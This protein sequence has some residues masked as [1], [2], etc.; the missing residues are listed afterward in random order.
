[1]K[2]I[3][4][5]NTSNFSSVVSNNR[6]FFVPKFQRDYSWES[7][8][9]DDLWQDIETML[10]EDEEHYMGYLVLQTQDEK[11][12]HI[13]DG[14]QRFTTII[15]LILAAVK[16][17]ERL[18]EKGVEPEANKRRIETLKG[19]Y[20]GKEDPVTLEYDNLL[21]LNRNNNPFFRDY[22]VKLGDLR[23]RNLK[24][25]EKLMKHCFEFFDSRLKGKYDNGKD[26]ASFIQSVVDNLYF[27]QIVVND[28]MNAF[29]VF[30][31][32]N[33]RGV[34]LSSSDLLKNYLFMLVDRDSSH[35]SHIEILEEKWA[36][37]TDNIKAERLPEFL[38]YYW[39]IQHK[40]IR[41]NDVFKTIRREITSNTGVFGL[42]RE[43]MQYS[44]VYMALHDEN[45]DLWE[46]AEV[47]SY[48]ALLRLFRLKQPYSVLMAAKINLPDKDFKELL[49]TIIILCFRYNVICDRNPNDQEGPFNALAMLI[50]KEQR[51]DYS[52]LAP[53][54]IE[55]RDFENAFVEKSF[56]YN[57]NNAKVVR[58]ILGRIEHFKG[59]TLDVQFD[60]ENASVEHILPQNYDESWGIEEDKAP[61]LVW[62]LGN[63]CLLERQ[64]NRELKDAPFKEKLPV[65]ATS[66][67]YYAQRISS[68]YIEWSEKSINK[69]Q[70]EMAKAAISIWRVQGI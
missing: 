46:D 34:Q 36:Q 50:S 37:L 69:F 52:L 6:R 22:I 29:R 51:V 8:Q 55:D 61:R 40:A 3:Q 10:A 56:P 41:S 45:D 4:N 16:N 70:K 59:S 13:I 67:Y 20:L 42:V 1:M 27:T 44:D 28:E 30:E 19:I 57:S 9:W 11:N 18:V 58:Y 54:V 7:E 53:I 24:A 23:A 31:T 12:Y 62:R 15:L 63:T 5:T 25:T 21:E 65:Y 68:E 2:G 66:S 32:L 38:R 26:Y 60:D 39:N 17:I 14:Q 49:K 47:R 33:A 48:V 64:L 35:E 43:M